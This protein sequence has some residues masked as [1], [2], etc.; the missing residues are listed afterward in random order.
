[1]TLSKNAPNFS[2]AALANLNET[3]TEWRQDLDDLASDLVS[4]DELLA[5]CLDG[6]DAD[7]EQGWNDYVDALSA[8]VARTLEALHDAAAAD[9]AEFR[10]EGKPLAAAALVG[11]ESIRHYDVARRATGAHATGLVCQEFWAFVWPEEGL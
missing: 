1:M 6:A 11:C 7:R 5:R 2:P 9:A 4:T 8:I 3:G 10:A